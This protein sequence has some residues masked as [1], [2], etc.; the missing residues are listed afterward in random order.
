MSVPL[1]FQLPHALLIAFL[2]E[3]LD[4]STLGKLDSA[5]SAKKYR[6]QFLSSLRDMISTSVDSYSDS[7]CRRFSWN[8]RATVVEWTGR[9]WRWLSIRHIY[10]ER[11]TVFGCKINSVLAV[12]SIRELTVKDCN[13]RG[14]LLLTRGCPALRSLTVRWQNVRRDEKHLTEAALVALARNCKEFSLYRHG[15]FAPWNTTNSQP[16]IWFNCSVDVQN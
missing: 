8:L 3:W 5:I 2:S 14:L 11:A 12:P 1:L 6:P 16:R 4:M 15:P 7:Y 13:N 9:W 10:V